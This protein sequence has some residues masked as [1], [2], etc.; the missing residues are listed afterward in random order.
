MPQTV[1]DLGKLVKQKYPGSYDDLADADLGVLVKQKYPGAYD[2]FADAAPVIPGTEKTG[3]PGVPIMQ[4]V[5]REIGEQ[6]YRE[7]KF[8][9]D[10]PQIV[11]AAK[12]VDEYNAQ[13]PGLARMAQRG[14]V[15]GELGKGLISSIPMV[16][17]SS[18]ATLEAIL[19]SVG[20]DSAAN[21]AA[22]G[23]EWGKEARD[24]Q[25]AR[26]PDVTKIQSAQDTLD[27]LSY[28]SGQSAGQIAATL[29]AAVVGNKLGGPLGA[30]AAG[31][32]MSYFQNTGEIYEGLK[33]KGV[34][35][36]KTALAAGVPA[37]LLDYLV[38]GGMAGKLAGRGVT[39]Q[40]VREG[41]KSAGME[42]ATE[43]GQEGVAMAAELLAGASV[44]AKEAVTRGINAAA[45]GFAAGPIGSGIEAYAEAR[46]RGFSP[47]VAAQVAQVATKRPPVAGVPQESSTVNR[48]DQGK[49]ERETANIP[50]RPPA[51]PA[52]PATPV[53][54]LFEQAAALAR[55][56]GRISRS[57][58]AKA[59]GVS[60]EEAKAIFGQLWDAQVIN[61]LGRA[62]QVPAQESAP[63]PDDQPLDS[64]GPAETPE[65]A[66]EEEMPLATEPPAP[67]TPEPQTEAA[68]T[69]AEITP[70]PVEREGH[71]AVYDHDAGGFRSVPLQAPIPAAEAI[72]RW[73]SLAPG[74]VIES[75]DGPMTVVRADHQKG[76]TAP[77][78]TVKDREGKSW[79]L[80]RGHI[81]GWI[82]PPEASPAP[83]QIEAAESQPEHTEAEVEQVAP[84]AQEQAASAEEQQ[85]DQLVEPAQDTEQNRTAEW[86]GYQAGEPV[87]WTPK[88]RK[89]ELTGKVIGG[90]QLGVQ[91]QVGPKPGGKI[92][93]ATVFVPAAQLA[94]DTRPAEEAER[95][96]AQEAKRQRAEPYLG[97]HNVEW[98]YDGKLFQAQVEHEGLGPSELPVVNEHGQLKVR[99]HSIDG[100]LATGNQTQWV[101]A[102]K[103]TQG[104]TAHHGYKVGDRV[105]WEGFAPKGKKA[106]ILSGTV[107]EV[108]REGWLK[109]DTGDGRSERPYY[110]NVRR[111]KD[112]EP[113]P[114]KKRKK[115]GANAGIDAAA[116]TPT[117]ETET[118]DGGTDAVSEPDA[119][120]AK[121]P[122]PLAEAPAE[123][124]RGAETQGQA[125]SGGVRGAGDD[126]GSATGS[127]A[128]A[129]DAL[130]AGDR[131]GES[132][133][134]S[135]SG[136]DGSPQP[137]VRSRVA[138][139]ASATPRNDYRITDADR[140]GE[141]S[142]REKVKANIE[143]IRLLKQ[144][145]EEK[146]DATPEERAVLVKYTGWG[147][148]AKAFEWSYDREWS[149]VKAELEALLTDEEYKSARASTPNAHYT[150][151]LVIRAMWRMA[152]RLGLAAGSSVLEPSMGVG[153]F[154]GFMPEAL[155]TGAKRTGIELD[156]IT[157]RIAKL[158]YPDSA[159]NVAGFE[160]VRLP[161][162]WFDLAISNVPFGNYGVHDPRY[163]RSPITR[164][165]HD[166]FFGK[167]LDKVRPGGLVVFITSSF[168]MDKKDSTIR[169]YLAD[170]ADLVAAFRLPNT[171]FKGN[172]GT[173]VTTDLIIL[174]KR[175][176]QT[177]PKS[178]SWLNLAPFQAKTRRPDG[179][180]G[181]TE[182][183]VNEYYARHPQ[184]M[185][186]EL[187]VDRGMYSAE[188][189][190][191]QGELT[192]ELLDAAIA[193]LPENI[194]TPW[195]SGTDLSAGAVAAI[196]FPEA[197]AVKNHAYA[198]KDGVVMVREG[199]VFRPANVPKSTA[200]RIKAMLPV[201]DAV[202][203]VF[204]TQLSDASEHEIAAAR[205]KLNRVY[206]SFVKQHG[207][208]NLPANYKAFAADPDAPLLLSL[209]N[210]DPEAKTATKADVFS[211]R[212]IERYKPVEKVETA[213]EALAVTLNERG[214]IDWIRMQELTGRT[215]EELQEELGELIYQNPDTR[216]WEPQ[217]E[218]LSGNVRD[219]LAAAEAAAKSDPKY[220]RN[221]D[222]LRAV[223]PEDLEPAQIDVRL[224]A[225]WVPKEDVRDF[226]AELLGIYKGDIHVS[227]SEALA[228]WFV[229]LKRGK[230][231]TSNTTTWGDERY[232]AHELIQ[233]A[234]NLKS[235][236]VWDSH[237][238]GTRTVNQ[239]K[240]LAVREKQQKI[241]DRFPE[242]LWQEPERAKRLARQYND[243]FNNLRLREYNGSHLKLPGMARLTLT[244]QDLRP[245]QKN[246]VWRMLQ[247]GN[248]LLAHVVGAGK[249]F[250]MVAGAMEMRRL[251]LAKKP[252]IVVPNY[253][254]E[255]WGADFLRLYPTAN[256]F[257]AGKEHFAAGNRQKAMSRIATGNW[258]AVIVSYEAF[259]KLPVSDELFNGYLQKQIDEL[260]DYIR[261]ANK[262][263]SDKRLVKELEK[264]KK[265]LEAKIRDKAN[266]DEK[267]D[268][269]TFE[270]L[271][272]DQLFIDEAHNFKNLFFT[273][274][275]TRIAGLPNTESQRAF[276]M[277]VKTQH[278]IERNNG[279]GVVF[280]TGTPISNTM[281]EMF[282]MQRY[283]QPEYLRDHGMSHFD[284][285]AQ[286]FGESVTALELAPDGSGYRMNTRF[287]RFTNLPELV[288]GFR[289][290]ADVQTADM[291]KLPRPKVAGGKP[292][293]VAA[294][295][296]P[297][298]KEYVARLVKR[299]ERV[300]NVDPR[301]D[302]M[303]KITGDGRKAALDLR[304][305][306]PDA[307]DDPGSKVN[308]GVDKIHR[309]WK[310]TAAEKSTQLVFIDFS[311]PNAKKG[312]KSF[313]VY[314]DMRAKLEAR[315]VPAKE[316]AFIHDY[317]TDAEKKALFDSVNAGRVR[318][319]FGSTSKMGAGMNVQK[320]LIALHHMDAPWRP[321]DIEQRE[322]RIL[323]QGNGN[324]EVQ[325]Y[326]YVTEGSFDAYMWQTLET[327]A[328]FI[329]Q[330]MT[331]D[332]TVR[333]AEDLENAA[334]TY[335]E[336]KAISSGNP[337]V[338]EKVKVDL[339]IRKLDS[340]RR[341]HQSE[342]LKV[343]EKLGYLPRA[344]DFAGK[345]IE[346]IERDMA[347]RDAH[348]KEFTVG[349]KTFSGEGAREAAAQ[350]I[351]V[352][353][354]NSRGEKTP[355]HFGYYRGL[356][357]YTRPATVFLG[358]VPPL[359][360][361]TIEGVSTYS[362][363]SNPDN[364]MGT[365]M[366]IEATVRGLESTRDSYALELAEKQKAVEALEAEASKPFEHEEKLQELLKRQEELVKLLDLN[367]GD[368]QAAAA[369][370]TEGESQADAI[371][372]A[373]EAA[374]E[375]LKKRGTFSGTK[376]NSG[377]DPA[378]LRDLAIIGAAKM[379][380]G[381]RK[382]AAWSKAMLED[383]GGRVKPHLLRVYAAAKK[384]DFG[385]QRGSLSDRPVGPHGPIFSEFRH[386]AKGAI[387][388]LKKAQGGEA[389]AALYHPE[390]GD[391][392]LVWG[393]EGDRAN[394]FAGGYGLAKIAE[395]HKE[396]GILD[397]LPDVFPTLKRNPEKDAGNN[398]VL[399][400][401]RYKAVVTTE[402]RGS[403]KT[404]LLTMYEPKESAASGGLAGVPEAPLAGT[405]GT[406]PPAG[407][408]SMPPG[409]PDVDSTDPEAGF[410]S[411]AYLAPAVEGIQ[412]T[413]AFLTPTLG[414]IRNEG[415]SGEKLATLID[416]ATDAGEV[417]AG[418]RVA[419]LED[420]RLKKLTRD[421]RFELLDVLEGRA[422]PSSAAVQTAADEIRAIMDEIAAEAS[423]RNVLVRVTK[424]LAP[425]D[426]IPQGV[427][428]TAKQQERRDQGHAVRISYRRPFARRGD[429][430]PH[431]IPH[432]GRIHRRL[433]A[434]IVENLVRLGVVANEGAANLLLDEYIRFM[435]SGKRE[436][437]LIG[438]LVMSGQA[439]SEADA[440]AKLQRHR[441]G[442]QRSGSLEYSR[443][444]N[445]P[446]WDPDPVR[447]L[448]QSIA[449]QSIRLQQIA[450][451]GQDNQRIKRLINAVRREG[452]NYELVKKAADQIVGYANEP[453]TAL[454]RM[455]R[456]LR[457]WQGFKL[458][459]ASIANSVQGPLNTLL[460]A[461]LRAL[462]AG[463]AGVAS[464][465]GR[466]FG[467]ESGATLE[468][469]IN[470]SLRHAGASGE[471]L[472]LFLK[473]TG[474]TATE[475]ANRI[476]AANAGAN[477]VKRM[478]QR[479]LLGDQRAKAVLADLGLDF[480]AIRLRGSLD[481]NDVLQAAKRFSDLTQFRSRPQDLP[482]FANSEMGKIFFQFKNYIYGQTR[483]IG[484]ELARDFR[485]GSYGRATRDFLVLAAVFPVTGAAVRAIRNLLTGRED[486]EDK[487]ALDRWFE[488]VAA[489]GAAG[490]LG[491]LIEAS[492]YPS[493]A[494]EWLVGPTVSEAG[495][496]ADLVINPNWRKLMKRIP[497]LGQILAE[498]VTPARRG[499][500]GSTDP[501]LRRLQR[502]ERRL[503]AS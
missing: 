443:E 402:W 482:M 278:L 164:S 295:A 408:S 78:I 490:F 10:N 370:Q 397:L 39:G 86:H 274:K 344:I 250:A 272:V 136:R 460:A 251:G 92:K 377:I 80:S 341:S 317:N 192:P 462:A 110:A 51:A 74:D 474:F 309:I 198:V 257:I 13:N 338:M 143:A 267:D 406:T 480:G 376:L 382:F 133:V 11:E 249:T 36:P 108:E 433:R 394:D 294:A 449:R 118:P 79:V 55:A 41:L 364:P 447:V 440:L 222:A 138:D 121:D 19:R 18:A 291:L 384:I 8:R 7:D 405:G 127:D 116:E 379:A 130:R 387:D 436:Q 354:E 439:R 423:G 300:K 334:L 25:A 32:A 398:L 216:G 140:V 400:N 162:N 353:L 26:V 429:Y 210:Y 159:V 5:V 467:I 281:A 235:P 199:D 172:A 292:Q 2:D 248:T 188:T 103:L 237:N 386:D 203:E 336:M 259:G 421:E 230:L 307:P 331:G 432:H 455:G 285:W 46:A 91:V 61:G 323:R 131:D 95:K 425:G 356:K 139:R 335:A 190:E 6:E 42:A 301:V 194:V 163:K 146:R 448:P 266:R 4:P 256:V 254:V 498:R 158:L 141:G 168:T 113:K 273:T 358:D 365:L 422:R 170:R 452:G 191:L 383:L 169:K 444:I 252:L 233:D 147:G 492:K 503:L 75:P 150:S 361:V 260:E 342:R 37:A 35:A 306:L 308:L 374:C 58:I 393:W 496:I 298:L 381:A 264:A 431:V 135:D 62:V 87:R 60:Q 68:E 399:E 465:S 100:Q 414:R 329:A 151:P 404:W 85:P 319:L 132:R 181:E 390:I 486:D 208:L 418:K 348:P 420:Q 98:T 441:L 495:K 396:Q 304:L 48:N 247:R 224:G 84:V 114:E 167:A 369:E 268:T 313:N 288:N 347:T 109:V 112:A 411:A 204:R 206:D 83:E 277:Y 385:S 245:H 468:S 413:Q 243:T 487:S 153:H 416:R 144:I 419:R 284:A 122:G 325:I 360:G 339:E 234:L 16:A 209:E 196:E 193:R 174:Q 232:Y 475:R 279:R 280:A 261:E 117:L 359:P 244:N 297:L 302:N 101:D 417:S 40:V 424:S 15:L 491:D 14:P 201:R 438:Y 311:T 90:N 314:D 123:D 165:I 471:A 499:G 53:E 99:M 366:S 355:A 289:T 463:F 485:T 63:V 332:V 337:A 371:E 120:R 240:T 44:T 453:D 96:A 64:D 477:Y 450:A 401:E 126:S 241:K 1:A 155:L 310:G 415:R 328:K 160:A 72:A 299:A 137:R 437:R 9:R 276:D 178:E 154:F 357:L 242:W 49:P 340:L 346:A 227:H 77:R 214:R 186:G 20:A 111:A 180:R 262:D 33:E 115:P 484:R 107:T 488:G 351:A 458:G 409:A 378:D 426:P 454:A 255:Q 166:Y 212:T 23:R 481:R 189:K 176:P 148:L 321:S 434:D 182:V 70:E 29:A 246:S 312:D 184:N 269:V 456:F 479:A 175:E 349:S 73:G 270:D 197:G 333:H 318:I 497:F 501:E 102:A 367:K 71:V 326:R 388:A 81:E 161:D 226:I 211:K 350:A 430:F 142:P 345:T 171:A 93:D 303:L 65:V 27:W 407:N 54:N 82:A 343:R 3:L 218:Y 22:K 76:R 265:R 21:V 57:Q 372:D 225:S 12:A 293:G 17:G 97:Y 271:G 403:K 59:F 238:D 392:D 156:S 290:V 157:G 94:R 464:K 446:F 327:K 177:A 67:V 56:Q 373:E 478:Y 282:T 69:Q 185:L 286:N 457:A 296:T 442:Q 466:R 202:R 38:P 213:S 476:F 187:A 223:Q 253:L 451:F 493:G 428:L 149:G 320:R 50:A 88:G 236:T 30:A 502:E 195:E 395:K 66:I 128:P 34:E 435:Q 105:E 380:R 362:A 24:A 472:S 89:T 31:I 375:R 229:E 207:P 45:G 43:T 239:E 145:E 352:W 316:I 363:N 183:T 205:Q 220:Q 461:D 263:K 473:A 129:E 173:E 469:V 124:V 459:L 106:P 104:W 119:A 287:A 219:K 125:D 389:I 324:P 412:A 179:S 275:M 445:L 28:Q 47:E 494:L 221:V 258:D 215:P 200:D 152:E 283:L 410:V 483:L 500:G 368:Q 391:I 315:G 305:V 470:E 134:V 231:N 322:G 52:A 489:L 427:T 330:V 228:Q 217:D